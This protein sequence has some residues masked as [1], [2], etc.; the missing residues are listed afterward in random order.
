MYIDKNVFYWQSFTQQ[1][2]EPPIIFPLE[3]KDGKGSN[4]AVTMQIKYQGNQQT[5]RDVISQTW[6]LTNN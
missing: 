4:F 3:T 5:Q 1:S 2:S 6:N